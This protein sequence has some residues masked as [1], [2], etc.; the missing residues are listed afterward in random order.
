MKPRGRH[1]DVARRQRARQREVGGELPVG[2]VDGTVLNHVP[3][4]ATLYMAKGHIVRERR[5]P[6]ARQIGDHRHGL[7]QGLGRAAPLECERGDEPRASALEHL[8]L[9]AELAEHVAT[10]GL[11]SPADEDGVRVEL[12]QG[13]HSLNG[14]GDVS[15][16]A[17]RAAHRLQHPRD[18]D[19]PLA[20]LIG[21]GGEAVFE[22]LAR[23]KV[24]S[25]DQPLEHGDCSVGEGRLQL[26]ER[27]R[28]DHA[29]ARGPHLLKSLSGVANAFA[30]E[31][32]EPR[33][34]HVRHHDRTG[35]RSPNRVD[36]VQ[37]LAERGTSQTRRR[38][39]QPGEAALAFVGLLVDERVQASTGGRVHPAFDLGNEAA[40]RRDHCLGGHALG[41]AD[42]GDHHPA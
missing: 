18:T 40:L 2:P 31:L 33:A 28:E 39:P 36:L 5:P 21:R 34:M 19:Q 35:T 22:A 37:D 25:A 1:P 12:V 30:R 17:R 3:L 16:A 24:G 20:A 7:A 4:P 41:H 15:S 29:P 38:L 13:R 27:G 11:R 6:I 23:A 32:R 14:F 26:P 10:A 9:G 8:V 42:A